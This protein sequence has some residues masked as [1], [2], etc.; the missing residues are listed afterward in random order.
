L[1]IG[2]EAMKGFSYK[3]IYEETGRRVLEVNVLPEKQCNFDCVF[4]PI[5]RSKDKVDTQR[6]FDGLEE[7]LAEL[8]R[9]IEE[10]KPDL[11]FINSMGEAFVHQGIGE[12][13]DLIRSTG[14]A[15]RLLSNGY[16]LGRDE[17]MAIANRC[18]EVVG[19]LKTISEERFQK[20]QRPM[21]D[22]TLSEYLRNME[23]FR[24]QYGGKFILEVTAIKGCNDDHVSVLRTKAAV[25]RISPDVLEVVRI[26]E[27]RFQKA[28]GVTPERLEE[29]ERELRDAL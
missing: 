3:K 7:S 29:I 24:R 9:R 12:I 16:L 17:Y 25:R 21:E 28:L 23:A 18:D 14:T 19:E 26:E 20:F 6:P 10:D 27:E 11:V 15:V 5:G 13:V 2:G 1:I 22:Y 4:C 8:R